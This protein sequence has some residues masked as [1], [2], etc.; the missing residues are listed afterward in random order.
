MQWLKKNLTLAIV[1]SLLVIGASALT[2][3]TTLQVQA[4]QH[5]DRQELSQEYVPR[6]EIDA[7][8]EAFQDKLDLIH[9]DVK[10]NQRLLIDHLID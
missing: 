1:L 8:E 7:R 9:E 4:G 10:E 6:L 5:L 3:F 2:A